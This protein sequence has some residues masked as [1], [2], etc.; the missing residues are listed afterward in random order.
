[1][2][3]GHEFSNI[4]MPIHEQGVTSGGRIF[5]GR[6]CWLGQGAAIVCNHGELTIGRNSVVG[7]N[8]VVTRSFPPFS[9]IAGNPATLIREYDQRTGT[10][11][12]AGAACQ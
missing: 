6:N 3:H 9:V 1:M 11:V 8:A 12:K 10:W 7:A 2:D 5:I 4:E